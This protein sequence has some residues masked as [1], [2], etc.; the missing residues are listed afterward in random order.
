MWT[1]PHV[2]MPTGAP[3]TYLGYTVKLSNME[4]L[5]SKKAGNSEQ[6]CNSERFCND[7]KVPYH[8]VSLYV[9]GLKTKVFC[10]KKPKSIFPW[11]RNLQCQYFSEK[12]PKR[13]KIYQPNL[14]AQ[15]QKFG[16]SLKKG[17]TG[18]P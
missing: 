9:L 13:P 2:H 3:D 18:R 7:Q 1:R 17:F 10:R 16:I 6:P 4:R 8:Q 14:S 12:C 15:A 5:N 11:S